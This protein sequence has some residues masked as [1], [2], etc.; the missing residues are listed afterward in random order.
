MQHFL[1]GITQAPGNKTQQRI[2]THATRIFMER[3]FRRITVEELCAGIAMSK[4]T[5]YKYFPNRDELVR[6]VFFHTVIPHVRRIVENFQSDLPVPEILQRHFDYVINGFFV[7]VTQLFLE[8]LQTLMPE[9]WAE[10]EQRRDVI[11]EFVGDLIRRGQAEGTVNPNLPAKR[12]A[13]LIETIFRAVAN[14]QA[15]AAMGMNLQDV[16][17]TLSVL[18]LEGVLRACHEEDE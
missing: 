12:F 9:F 15:A 8:D 5:F 7:S 4:R 10:I 18:V 6:A 14:P 17:S 11:V 13:R 2:I 1:A 16:A 3:G